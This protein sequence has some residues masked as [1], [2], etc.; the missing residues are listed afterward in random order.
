M[1]CALPLR[2]VSFNGSGALV[3][4]LTGW[5]LAFVSSIDAGLAL[6]A[7]V[8]GFGGDSVLEFEDGV[9][10]FDGDSVLEFEDCIWAFKSATFTGAAEVVVFALRREVAD[11]IVLTGEVEECFGSLEVLVEDV[12]I[13]CNFGLITTTASSSMAMIFGS[14]CLDA[15]RGLGLICADMVSFLTSVAGGGVFETAALLG[16][17]SFLYVLSATR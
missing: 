11:V 14:T 5:V 7:E 8:V 10:A 4:V 17:E 13:G 1:V 15:F 9:W 16:C 6:P 3:L 12:S 2:L